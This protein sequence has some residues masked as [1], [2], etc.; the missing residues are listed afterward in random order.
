MSFKKMSLR[1][2]A[3]FRMFPSYFC[4]S[5][6]MILKAR[7]SIGQIMIQIAFKTMQYHNGS[8]R[9]MWVMTAAKSRKVEP[10]AACGVDH[11]SWAE[12]ALLSLL[13]CGVGHNMSKLRAC[14]PLWAVV[15]SLYKHTSLAIYQPLRA[16]HWLAVLAVR[17]N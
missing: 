10:N 4:V 17:A 9:W 3:I 13:A 16:C 11:S 12:L 6:I 1:Y 2:L 5:L 15:L 8:M 7:R 14:Q